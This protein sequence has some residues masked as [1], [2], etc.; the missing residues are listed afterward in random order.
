M[1]IIDRYIIQEIVKP[2]IVV[3]VVLVSIFAGYSATRYLADATAGLLSAKT[4]FCLVLLKVIIALEV[5]LPT[6][7]YLSIVV[8][9]GRLH[10]DLE[11]TALEACGVRRSQIY[12]NVL[13]IAVLVGIMVASLSL[14][15]RPWTYRTAY[16]LKKRSKS[17]FQI[18]R[19]EPA[20]FYELES[21]KRVIFARQVS[22]KKQRARQVFIRTR[23]EGRQQIVTAQEVS[24][25]T[26]Q[27][28][29][30]D[31][32]VFR[33]GTIYELSSTDQRDTTVEFKQYALS[34]N[35][36]D[37]PPI[38]KIKAAPTRNLVNSD[39][40][41]AIAELQWR[42]S[43]PLTTIILALLA[44]PLSQT[45]P[46]KG[47]YAKVTLAVA[48]YGIFYILSL[49]AKTWVGEQVIGPWPGIWGIEGVMLLLLLM[50]TMHFFQP[51]QRAKKG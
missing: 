44:I 23:E 45:S 47:Q 46:R 27:A 40:P 24:Q 1:K 41:F 6:T 37:I 35:P 36:P 30:N 33:N 21:G 38:T 3:C 11:M 9:L 15:V 49:V 13:L 22:K 34:L 25:R 43:T 14:F 28:T 5:L 29:G 18:K 7:I 12:R 42:F 19:M 17:H 2:S 20:S 26:D 51:W 50:T 4:V 10:S 31:V 8:G 39:N 48:V 16:Q 32:L